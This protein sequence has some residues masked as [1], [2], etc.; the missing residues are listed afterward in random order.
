M[1]PFS[2]ELSETKFYSITESIMTLPGI[3]SCL[4]ITQFV[5]KCLPI[6]IPSPLNRHPM[7]FRAVIQEK[8]LR[9]LKA[10]SV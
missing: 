4:I 8:K 7:G 10:L 2:L 9:D 1:L 6:D 5:V 3:N